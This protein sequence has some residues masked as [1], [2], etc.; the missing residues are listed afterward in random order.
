MRRLRIQKLFDFTLLVCVLIL[1]VCGIFFVYSACLN[2]PKPWAKT[3][4]IRQIVWAVTG[5]IMMLVFAVIN[6]NI[7]YR[8]SP[9]IFAGFLIV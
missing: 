6:Y 4:Y 8:Y 9:H 2:I 3:Q 1:T 7:F 5:I